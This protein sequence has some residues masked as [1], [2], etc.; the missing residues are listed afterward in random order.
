M[1]A[2]RGW[3]DQGQL[4]P[5]LPGDS[6]LT[7][8]EPGGQWRALGTSNSPKFPRWSTVWLGP[9]IKSLGGIRNV[10][11]RPVLIFNQIILD[12]FELSAKHI[13]GALLPG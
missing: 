10:K 2:C 3:R 6:P 4:R 13:H 8:P 7:G 11:W 1:R 5:L 12:T 9:Q